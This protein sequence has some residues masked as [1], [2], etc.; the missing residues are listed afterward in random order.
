MMCGVQGSVV[1]GHCSWWAMQ[2]TCVAL[3]GLCE[4]YRQSTAKKCH[5]HCQPS[6]H[7]QMQRYSR[8]AGAWCSGYVIDASKE[9]A[10]CE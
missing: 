1:Q 6:Q 5:S 9:K 7:A 8:S 2:W 4:I 10:R 3:G